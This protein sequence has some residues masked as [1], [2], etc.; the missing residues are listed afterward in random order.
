[1]G[2]VLKLT[3]NYYKIS[4]WK[5][6]VNI[7]KTLKNNEDSSMKLVDLNIEPLTL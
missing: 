5:L 3:D 4:T 6:L 7:S 2:L 1:M